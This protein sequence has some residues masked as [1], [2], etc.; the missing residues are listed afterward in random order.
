MNFSKKILLNKFFK[1]ANINSYYGISIEKLVG[2]NP[3]YKKVLNIE[4]KKEGFDILNNLRSRLES[5]NQSKLNFWISED[6]NVLSITFGAN[7]LYTKYLL[8]IIEDRCDDCEEIY[9]INYKDFLE[10]KNEKFL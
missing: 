4:D 8:K 3:I 10:S 1:T 7:K 5:G 2:K 9:E 6:N